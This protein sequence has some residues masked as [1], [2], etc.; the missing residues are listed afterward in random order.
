MIISGISP[1]DNEPMSE[2]PKII[3]RQIIRTVSNSTVVL[4][5]NHRKLGSKRDLFINA[6]TFSRH[7]LRISSAF[8]YVNLFS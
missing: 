2:Y 8:S 4:L 5:L 3:V 7:L 1:L 6:L